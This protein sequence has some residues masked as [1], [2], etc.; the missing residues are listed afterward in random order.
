VPGYRLAYESPMEIR[1]AGD[2]SMPIFRVF[3]VVR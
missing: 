3:E 1:T 2:S